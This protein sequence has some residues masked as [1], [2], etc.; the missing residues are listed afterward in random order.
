M[1]VTDTKLIYNCCS[2][3]SEIKMKDEFIKNK[4]SFK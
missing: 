4:I 3:C 2:K 1:D